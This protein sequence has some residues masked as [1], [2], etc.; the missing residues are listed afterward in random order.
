MGLRSRVYAVA[1]LPGTFGLAVAL[2]TLT[3]TTR[4]WAIRELVMQV[5]RVERAALM[6]LFLGACVT[7]AGACVAIGFAYGATVLF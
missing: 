4:G 6:T 2:L 7:F 5:R 3:G 1:L